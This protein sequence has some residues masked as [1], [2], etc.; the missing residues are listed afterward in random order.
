[1]NIWKKAL[2]ALTLISCGSVLHAADEEESK[3]ELT[4]DD[5]KKLAL[6]KLRAFSKKISTE[7]IK[8]DSHPAGLLEVIGILDIRLSASRAYL[9]AQILMKLCPEVD[10]T[11]LPLKLDCVTLPAVTKYIAPDCHEDWTRAAWAIAHPTPFKEVEMR[12]NARGECE[13]WM[14]TNDDKLYC[15]HEQLQEAATFIRRHPELFADAHFWGASFAFFMKN[16]TIPAEE[17]QPFIEQILTSKLFKNILG[18]EMRAF[19]C[20]EL[21]SELTKDRGAVAPAGASLS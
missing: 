11:V 1:M 3:A 7:E 5:F 9:L 16:L 18:E 17:F 13:L 8:D 19:M 20:E 4:R 21:L 10:V 12:H 2:L 15:P 6:K 14:K